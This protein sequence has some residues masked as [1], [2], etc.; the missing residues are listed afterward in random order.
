MC[1][2]EPTPST[3]R[4]DRLMRGPTGTK[5]RKLVFALPF[6][7]HAELQVAAKGAGLSTSQYLRRLVV[8]DID[9]RKTTR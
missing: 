4:Y 1:H 2:A 3:A 6:D 9:S 8:A 7:A 5:S